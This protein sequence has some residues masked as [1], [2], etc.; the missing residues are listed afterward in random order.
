MSH[1]LHSTL[2]ITHTTGFPFMDLTGAVTTRAD[3]GGVPVVHATQTEWTRWNSKS[4]TALLP[5]V[6]AGLLTVPSIPARPLVPRTVTS[7]T[8]LFRFNVDLDRGRHCRMTTGQATTAA[9]DARGFRAL[10]VEFLVPPTLAT[11]PDSPK[12]SLYQVTVHGLVPVAEGTIELN[13]TTL[14]GT[15]SLGT[16][17]AFSTLDA[18]HYRVVV[19]PAFDPAHPLA[20]GDFTVVAPPRCTSLRTHSPPITVQRTTSAASHP[21]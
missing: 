19:T 8:V 17:L 9:R 15:V 7:P 16:L 20:M 11:L 1:G 14:H 21:Y 12:V 3:R 10:Q 13:S 6:P 4:L 5:V 18:G 2:Y